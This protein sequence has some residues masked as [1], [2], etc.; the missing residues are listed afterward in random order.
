MTRERLK[1]LKAL[2]K[3]AEHLEEEI[4]TMPFTTGGY[5][6]D[7]ANNY[8][9]GSPKPFVIQG[10]STQKYDRLKETLRRKLRDIQSE[11]AELEEWLESVEDPE[12]RDILRL[13]Y[14][15]G[16][17][18]EEIAEELRYSVITVK[19]R[20]KRFWKNDTE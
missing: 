10:Y 7:S 12:L 17:T 18:Q 2:L 15:N 16:L 1:K 19:R 6:G 13:Q 8:S 14:V 20:L 4:K 3:E 9:T 11:I 5:V